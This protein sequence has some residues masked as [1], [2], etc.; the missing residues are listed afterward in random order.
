[1]FDADTGKLADL[2]EFHGAELGPAGSAGPGGAPHGPRPQRPAEDDARLWPLY[3]ALLPS[4]AAGTPGVPWESR[5]V[6]DE[7]RS[8]FARL[9][10][11][12]LSM[13]YRTLGHAFMSWVETDEP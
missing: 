10:E 5:A 13:H 6:A 2:R 3:D 9:M 12:S 7:F 1:M 4:F 11:P 8:L